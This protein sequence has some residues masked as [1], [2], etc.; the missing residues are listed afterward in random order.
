MHAHDTVA[1][2]VLF[3]YTSTKYVKGGQQQG[4]SIQHLFNANR[5]AIHRRYFHRIK[6]QYPTSCLNLLLVVRLCRILMLRSVA[7]PSL[8]FSLQ[9][10]TP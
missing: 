9:P 7:G 4:I 5:L 6:I 2:F 3:R 1:Y 10:S 8:T